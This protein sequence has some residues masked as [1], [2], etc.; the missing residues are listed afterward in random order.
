MSLSTNAD[1][2]SGGELARERRERWRSSSI[3]TLSMCCC[4]LSTVCRCSSC[5][6]CIWSYHMEQTCLVLYMH[7]VY[8]IEQT[9]FLVL[10]MYLVISYGKDLF[11]TLYV[12]DPIIWSYG[13]NQFHSLHVSDLIVMNSLFS[14]L[15]AEVTAWTHAI[16][17]WLLPIWLPVHMPS[18]TGCCKIGCLN[19]C[20]LWLAA[21]ELTA[22]THAAELVSI[23]LR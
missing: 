1:V 4:K 20:H 17:D 3:S 6:A 8:Y 18:I 7:L 16:Y 11:S 23:K 9:C 12:S 14:T 2:T 19:T 21:A 13:I 5:I 15:H 10:Y 22:C